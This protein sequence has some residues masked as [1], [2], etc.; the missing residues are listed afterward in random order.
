MPAVGLPALPVP[1]TVTPR[2]VAALISNELFF[3]PVVIKSFKSGSASIVLRG[4]GVRSR[5]PTTMTKPCNA[6]TA[7][8]W[9]ANGLSKTLI[10]TSLASVDQS[11]SF[12]ATF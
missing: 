9:L 12:N 3:A 5:I 6:L 11:A 10:S 4:N 2:S 1:Q 8:S 7:W